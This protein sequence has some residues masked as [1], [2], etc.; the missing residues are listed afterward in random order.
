MPKKLIGHCSL[1]CMTFSFGSHRQPQNFL[2]DLRRGN[3]YRS[4]DNLTLPL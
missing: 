1:I 2:G 4:S 3:P